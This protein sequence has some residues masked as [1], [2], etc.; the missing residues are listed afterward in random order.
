MKPWVKRHPRVA[1]A[2]L[3]LM[4]P[5]YP[6]LLLALQAPEIWREGFRDWSYEWREI[7]RYI[8]GRRG[9]PA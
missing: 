9:G 8:K 7:R 5:V 6:L 1:L 4:L 2:L 3:V